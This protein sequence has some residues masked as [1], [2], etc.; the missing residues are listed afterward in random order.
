M[1]RDSVQEDCVVKINRR[2]KPTLAERTSMSQFTPL[3]SHRLIEH[4]CKP[5]CRVQDRARGSARSCREMLSH[6]GFLV[7]MRV[8]VK[9]LDVQANSFTEILML[10]IPRTI[11]ELSSPVFL[12]LTI[13]L[14]F[15]HGTE[16]T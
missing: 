8:P 12:M 13:N 4:A 14:G 11:L 7:R 3:F 1:R 5:G 6:K 16:G 9:I 2:F 15:L 10:S